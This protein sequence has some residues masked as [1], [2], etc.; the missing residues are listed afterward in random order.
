MAK[1][2][3][4]GS[5]FYLFQSGVVIN[6]AGQLFDE[7]GEKLRSSLFCVTTVMLWTLVELKKNQKSKNQKNKYFGK[8]IPL[9]L[10][11]IICDTTEI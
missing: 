9:I 1:F 3:P 7:V 2:Y 4:N 11:Y 10:S 8:F 6:K 5:I